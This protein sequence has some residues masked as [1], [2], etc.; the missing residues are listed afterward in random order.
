M[1]TKDN[2]QKIVS[3][4]I[5]AKLVKIANEYVV[6]CINIEKPG[7]YSASQ[8]AE[9]KDAF[10]NKIYFSY[11]RWEFEKIMPIDKRFSVV[12]SAS[13]FSTD[14]IEALG[15]VPNF[16]LE[17]NAIAIDIFLIISKYERL[18]GIRSTD[19]NK[20][21]IGEP[22]TLYETERAKVVLFDYAKQKVVTKTKTLTIISDCLALY[23]TSKKDYFA[24]CLKIN[25]KWIE[26][27][28][29]LSHFDFDETIEQA[30]KVI[31]YERTKSGAEKY[32]A[33]NDNKYSDYA[34]MILAEFG[35]SAKIA[36]NKD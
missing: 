6:P 19:K 27:Y 32:I 23:P 25:S 17:F 22:T 18:A 10:G 34:R 21:I 9:R 8:L 16:K 1:K 2:A 30:K 14:E 35:E 11:D 13:D 20:F 31:T 7:R 28:I 33:N 26:V 4:K 12:I 3:A 36:Y 15:Y 29:A 24:Y 5:V